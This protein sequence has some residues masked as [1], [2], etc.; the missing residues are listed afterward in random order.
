M[1]DKEIKFIKNTLYLVLDKDV[2]DD[3]NAKIGKMLKQSFLDG[4]REQR[5]ADVE[6]CEESMNQWYF[7]TAQFLEKRELVMTEEEVK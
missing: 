7:E 2:A 3:V 5:K 1:T 6:A 4:A